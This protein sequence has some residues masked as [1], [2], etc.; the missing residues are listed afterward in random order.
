MLVV[1]ILYSH[2]SCMSYN[3]NGHWDSVYR[4]DNFNQCI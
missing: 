1:R 3:W 4:G 2:Q